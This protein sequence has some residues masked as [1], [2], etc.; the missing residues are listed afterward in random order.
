MT[1]VESDQAP[2]ALKTAVDKLIAVVAPDDGDAVVA[3]VP[4]RAEAS[5]Y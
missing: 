5:A 1:M 4:I 3:D 2:Q